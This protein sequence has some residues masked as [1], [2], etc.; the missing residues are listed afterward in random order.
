VPT[1]AAAVETLRDLPMYRLD[2]LLRRAPSLQ[3][4]RAGQIATAE[5][6]S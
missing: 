3:Q 5:Y 1:A 4:T 2:P 6:S